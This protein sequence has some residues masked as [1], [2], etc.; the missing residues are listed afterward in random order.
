MDKNSLK[1][2][3]LFMIMT[4]N[5]KSRLFSQTGTILQVKSEAGLSNQ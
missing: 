1:L 2:Y 5:K 4:K 3:P